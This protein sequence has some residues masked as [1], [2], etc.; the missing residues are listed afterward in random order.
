MGFN[1][2]LKLLYGLTSKLSSNSTS[3]FTLPMAYNKIFI[4]LVSTKHN[5]Y[6]LS[7]SDQGRCTNGN[8][9]IKITNTSIEFVDYC[10]GNPNYYLCIGI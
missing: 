7:N 1:N 10:W 9:I 3:T 4:A 2:G 8:G 6:N 5:T